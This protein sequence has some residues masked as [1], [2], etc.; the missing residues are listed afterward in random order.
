MAAYLALPFLRSCVPVQGEPFGLLSGLNFCLPRSCVPV[1]GGPFGLL[2]GLTLCLPR[3]CAPVK[4]PPFEYA[5]TEDK[6][7]HFLTYADNN[8]VGYFMKQGFTKEITLEK[9]RAGHHQGDCLRR[10]AVRPES[11]QQKTFLGKNM[12][13]IGRIEANSLDGRHP[14]INHVSRKSKLIACPPTSTDTM[15]AHSGGRATSRTTMV[16]H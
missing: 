8:A 3:S 7:S 12:A 10:G 13:Y 9:E 6:L 15:C 11:S 1:Q 2:S 14:G 16:E 5:C 4:G